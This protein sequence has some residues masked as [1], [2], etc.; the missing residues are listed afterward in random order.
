[1][2]IS[3]VVIYIDNRYYTSLFVENSKYNDYSIKRKECCRRTGDNHLVVVVGIVDS[4]PASKPALTRTTVWVN[5][6]NH[7]P[8]HISNHRCYINL[9]RYNLLILLIHPFNLALISSHKIIFSF[10]FIPQ[11]YGV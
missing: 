11:S 5:L 4:L 10:I 2:D 8:H 1:M 9:N 6:E 7:Q 3:Y